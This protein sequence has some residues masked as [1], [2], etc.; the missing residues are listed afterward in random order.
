MAVSDLDLELF[1][2]HGLD[3]APRVFVKDGDEPI[4]HLQ[5][6]S[7]NHDRLLRH[8]K[9]RIDDSEEAMSHFYPRWHVN[10]DKVQAYINL[11]DWEKVLKSKNDKSEA[12]QV[13][14]VVVP[15][16]WAMVSTVTTFIIH[17]FT[18]RKPIFQISTENQALLD[19]ARAME[20]ILQIQADKSRLIRQIVTEVYNGLVYGVG[21]RRSLWL[22]EVGWRTENNRVQQFTI[23][24]RPAGETIQKNRVR[25][26]V[27]EGN[28][29]FSIDPFHFLPDPRVPMSEVNR[30]GEYVFWRDY[31]GMHELLKGQAEGDYKYVKEIKPLGTDTFDENQS[32]RSRRA[33][34]FSMPGASHSRRAMRSG[35]FPQITEGTCEIVPRKFGLS[36]SEIPEK[37]FFTIGNMNQI[38]QA[39]PYDAD[40]DMHPVHVS[41]PFSMG[42]GFGNLGLVDYI[43]P[44]QDLV[45]WLFNSHMDNVRRVLNDTIVVDPM[46]VEMQDLRKPGPGRTIRMKRA[47]AGRDIRTFLQQLPVVDVTRGHIESAQALIGIA[48]M[49][50][51]VTDNILG[52]Q[53]QGGR[54]TATESRQA[55][56][57][58]S[59]RLAHLA[60][61]IS[62]Q[63]MQDNAEQWILNTQQFISEDFSMQVL[64]ADGKDLML[65]PGLL[66]GEFNF[67]VHDGTLPLD[68]VA[69][70]DIWRE[71]MGLALGDPELRQS[72][73]V[74]EMFQFVAELGG[75]K[76]IS[77]F[78][79]DVQPNEVVDAQAQAGNVVPLQ[80]PRLGEGSN[81]NERPA[82]RER[83]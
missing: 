10:E 37:W 74:P 77:R 22:E 7:D 4:D 41:E 43:N 29:S 79:L 8:L 20:K 47:A 14:S 52:L 72:I 50:S 46:M 68:R 48:Q 3:S 70:M 25:K 57:A 42:L 32:R 24:G 39:V 35:D 33:E 30:D 78:R 5:P 49:V 65:D 9:A 1:G 55:A 19:N 17:A 15:L 23:L 28:A 26:V 2:P 16:N 13:V 36:E 6:K 76:D 73:D 18:G 54:K 66:S 11:Q 81:M 75:A 58:A 51:A 21:A 56:Q 38:I 34:G 64:G 61:M 44:F 40:H 82:Q 80:V 69:L 53:D 59:S 31:V 45:S 83:Q 27:Y 12:P 62:S 63:S 71:V 67:Q 60:K